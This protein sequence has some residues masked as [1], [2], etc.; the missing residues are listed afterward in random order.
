MKDKLIVH[1]RNL[2]LAL[3]I[4]LVIGFMGIWNLEQILKLAVPGIFIIISLISLI[5]TRIIQERNRKKAD[6]KKKPNRK[7]QGKSK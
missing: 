2:A 7:R 1:A 3:L 4:S 6:N 5:I